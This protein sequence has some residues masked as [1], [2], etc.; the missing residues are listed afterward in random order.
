MPPFFLG[1]K[2]NKVFK[3]GLRMGH[4]SFAYN[5]RLISII[6]LMATPHMAEQT[7]GVP[8]HNSSPTDYAAMAALEGALSRMVHGDVVNLDFSRCRFI[9][10]AGVV[11]L[12]LFARRLVQRGVTVRF[13]VST[14][15]S[16]IEMNLTQNG[17][18]AA[19]GANQRGWSGNSIPFREDLTQNEDAVIEYL[20]K[21]WLGRGWVAVPDEMANEIAG[22]LL[23]VYVNAFEHGSSTVGVLS[24]G[25][26]FPR[27]KILSLAVGDYGVGIPSKAEQYYKARQVSGREAMAWA[28]TPGMTTLSNQGARGLGFH[29]LKEFVQKNDGVLEVYSHDGYAKVTG[30]GVVLESLETYVPA[31]IIQVKLSCDLA[32]YQMP[33]AKLRKFE[34]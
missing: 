6:R 28:F 2:T 27:K 7:F 8:T 26:H 21:E 14:M 5:P 4:A 1:T 22:N 9:D 10:P 20:Q 13:L 23:E 17:F 11:L 16:A 18:A 31:T 15:S 25:Q 33:D 32:K 19:M 29:F 24:C 3:L 30:S 34:W 12:G